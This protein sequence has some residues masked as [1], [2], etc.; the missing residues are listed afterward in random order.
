MDSSATLDDAATKAAAAAAAA[1]GGDDVLT[2][3]EQDQQNVAALKATMDAG[4][5]A[6]GFGPDSDTV[7]AEDL[8]PLVDIAPG[9]FKYVLIEA[10]NPTSGVVTLHTKS[11]RG[12]YHADVAG[13]FVAT[14]I[15]TARVGLASLLMAC[16]NTRMIFCC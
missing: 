10:T 11:G 8:V 6:S 7:A 9:R 13:G 3:S 4:A 1:A 2:T 16:C 14:S 5:A 15:A 12:S